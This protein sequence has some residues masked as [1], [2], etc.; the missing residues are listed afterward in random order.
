MQNKTYTRTA[1]AKINLYLD[2]LGKM[3]NGYHEIES[4]MQ[5]ISLSDEISLT[6]ASTSGE[7]IIEIT[8][9]SPYV[10]LNEKNLVHKAAVRFLSYLNENSPSQIESKRLSFHIEKNIPIEAG[11]AGGSTD[12]A[13]SLYLLNEAF[14]YPL[15][16]NELLSLGASLGADV[17]FCLTGGTAVCRG[18]GEKIT[19]LESKASM[20]LVCA[21]GDTGVS[22]PYAFGLIDEKFGTSPEPHGKIGKVAYSLKEGNISALSASLFNRFEAVIEPINASVSEIKA[23]M[24]RCGAVG[25][26]MSGSGPS[27]FGIFPDR[28][29]AE[30]AASSLKMKGLR[31][32]V[33]KTV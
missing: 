18:I 5:S 13:A 19:P 23:E 10:P 26:L 33:C 8:S 17:A 9:N 24:I 21:I 30:L 15:K 28:K 29:D 14:G 11:M 6:V 2:V 31:A 12:C 27:V 16:D 32:F 1:Y 3:E 22:T 25:A 7:I 4:V 20:S